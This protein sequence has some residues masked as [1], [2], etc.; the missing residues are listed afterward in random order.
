MGEDVLDV[1]TVGLGEFREL[2]LRHLDGHGV[3]L[4]REWG[5]PLELVPLHTG[6]GL[7]LLQLALVTHGS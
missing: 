2:L 4:T 1:T 3:N 5:A 7:F 6:L